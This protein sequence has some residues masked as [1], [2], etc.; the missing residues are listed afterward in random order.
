MADEITI[1]ATLSI[2]NGNY[3]ATRRTS[4]L[5]ATQSTLGGNAAVQS[6]ST[7]YEALAL[8][9]VS[10]E[11]WCYVR[12]LDSTN[13]VELGL[14]VSS[15]FYGFTKLEAGEPALFRVSDQTIYAQADTSAVK[16]DLLMLEE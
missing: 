13:F 9:D 7:S 1:N 16:I 3:A 12:N 6:V 15:T 11:G 4:R 10:T 5:Q 14:E 8:G 2:D